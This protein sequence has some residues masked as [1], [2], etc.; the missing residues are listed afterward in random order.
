MLRFF[1][2]KERY[3]SKKTTKPEVKFKNY[4]KK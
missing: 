2:K 4:Q 1:G 3:P